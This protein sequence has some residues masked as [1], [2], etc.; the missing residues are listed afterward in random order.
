MIVTGFPGHFKYI[1]DQIVRFFR[2][3]RERA[4]GK[5]LPDR[6]RVSAP[7]QFFSAEFVPRVYF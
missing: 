7:E 6:G 2:E 4:P 1:L 3:N 5:E